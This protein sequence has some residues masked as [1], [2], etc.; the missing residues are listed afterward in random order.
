MKAISIFI[1][2]AY[3]VF[4]GALMILW[5]GEVNVYLDDENQNLRIEKAALETEIEVW[6]ALRP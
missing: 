1:L 6:K 4:C 3:V 2:A 5:L